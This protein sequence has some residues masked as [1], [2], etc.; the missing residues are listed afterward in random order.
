M[1]A[2]HLP[3]YLQFTPTTPTCCHWDTIGI[4]NQVGG[5]QASSGG[6]INIA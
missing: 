3:G 1:P 2:A 6:N 5:Y 4:N